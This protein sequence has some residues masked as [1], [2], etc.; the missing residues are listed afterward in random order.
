MIY[1]ES[2]APSSICPERGDRRSYLS[3]P[4]KNIE[5]KARCRDLQKARQVAESLPAELLAEGEQSDTYFDSPEGRMKLR[6]ASFEDEASLIWYSRP[7]S[8]EPRQSEY[9]IARISRPEKLR[10]FLSSHF[11]VKVT[12]EKRRA[13]FL[14]GR[15]RIHLDELEG[16]GC[17]IEFEVPVDGSE[18]DAR[19]TVDELVS[20]FEI[21]PEDLV[22]ES[23]SDLLSD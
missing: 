15:A 17:F 20:F 19:R 6:E 14:Y 9:R 18:E 8:P 1:Y 16:L 23:Y 7:N 5:I 12:V 21:L 11:G 3:E 13:I 22:A 10:E 2:L 4:M